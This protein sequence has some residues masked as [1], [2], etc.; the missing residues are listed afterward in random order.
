MIIPVDEP[1][2]SNGI[3]LLAPQNDQVF[4]NY[5][6]IWIIMKTKS[7]YLQELE[8]KWLALK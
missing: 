7:G 3:G 1:K 4:I 6:N 8:D 2:F 5:L